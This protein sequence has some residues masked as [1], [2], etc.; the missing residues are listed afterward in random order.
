MRGHIK[1]RSKGSWSII[2]E[3]P[4]DAQGKRRQKWVTVQGTKKKAQKKLTELLRQLDTGTFIDPHKLTLGQYLEKWLS[5]YAENKVS[6][7]T[8]VRYRA[9][10]RKHLI[11]SLGAVPLMALQQRPMLIQDYYAAALSKGR[12]DGKGALSAQTVKHHHR[13]L[14][15]ALKQAVKWNLVVNNPCG[16]VDPPKP[17]SKEIVTVTDQDIGKLLKAAEGHRLYN[18]LLLEF[19]TGL[20]RGEL[21][22]LMWKD[23]DMK[24]GK[25]SVS[26]SVEQSRAFGVQF[27]VP[28]TKRSRRS[29]ALPSVMLEALRRHRINQKK[30][31]LRAG[32]LYNDQGLVFCNQDGS[33]W[34][35][36]AFTSAFR[37]LVKRSGIVHTRFHD[38]RHTHAT[39]LLRQ[40]INPKIVSERL[41][42]SSIAITLDTYSHVLPDMQEMAAERID[43]A[44]RD[45]INRS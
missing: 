9:I 2:V 26:R 3:L 37:K 12:I 29:L 24:S 40:G 41:G 17:E 23:I 6:H 8:L 4:R 15:E 18:P 14:S 13:V 21:L 10:C 25:L 1:Q 42:H 11:P 20:R 5:E 7:T 44:L 31:K 27:K 34:K 35:P 39:Q 32:P 19:A 45:V 22:G 28:K 33:I 38:I 43:Q 36:D 16:A 30:E